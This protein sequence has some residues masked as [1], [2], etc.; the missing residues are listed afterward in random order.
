[1]K[2]Y[3]DMLYKQALYSQTHIAWAVCFEKQCGA[4]WHSYKRVKMINVA[5]S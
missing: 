4:S 2:V 1:M 3:L 5:D